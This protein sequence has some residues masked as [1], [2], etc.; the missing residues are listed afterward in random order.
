M[1]N[2]LVLY[3]TL[4]SLYFHK[5]LLPWDLFIVVRSILKRASIYMWKWTFMFSGFW[6]TSRSVSNTDNLISQWILIALVCFVHCLKG[7]VKGFQVHLRS[8]NL[9]KYLWSHDQMKFVTDFLICFVLGYH[10]QENHT[11]F[12]SSGV[13]H[14]GSFRYSREFFEIS[15]LFIFSFLHFPKDFIKTDKTSLL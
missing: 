11:T 12:L 6:D 5:I 1:S 4:R 8:L 2:K 14:E 15:M 3:Q 7:P 13:H 9:C 10:W